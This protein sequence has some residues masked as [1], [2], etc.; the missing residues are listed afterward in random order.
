MMEIAEE[1]DERIDSFLSDM[2]AE[3]NRSLGIDDVF[4][5]M[6]G[7]IDFKL[8]GYGNIEKKINKIIEKSMEEN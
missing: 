7:Y 4:K 2:T 6:A 1:F 8:N 5:L 3:Y